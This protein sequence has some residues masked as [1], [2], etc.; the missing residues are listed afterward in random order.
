MNIEDNSHLWSGGVEQGSGALLIPWVDGRSVETGAVRIPEKSVAHLVSAL[1]GNMPPGNETVVRMMRQTL[2]GKVPA[3][4][5]GAAVEG[6]AQMA[7]LLMEQAAEVSR[8]QHDTKVRGGRRVYGAQTVTGTG[9][10]KD[11]L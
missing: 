9:A 5:L 11:A 6:A 3:A 2:A 8:M 10:Y 7:G 4:C 1:L